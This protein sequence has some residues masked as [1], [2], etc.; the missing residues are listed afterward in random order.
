M[1]K[2]S[3]VQKKMTRK[4]RQAKDKKK[5]AKS[6]KGAMK[7]ADAVAPVCKACFSVFYPPNDKLK[8]LQ[9]HY[10]NCAKAASKKM[11]FDQCFPCAND[12]TPAPSKSNNQN[13][14]QEKKPKKK[15]KKRKGG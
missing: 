12:P 11:S 5:E 2:G 14:N 13:Q 9:A 7:K 15:K 3:N 6:N 4:A 10:N 1:G 8:G